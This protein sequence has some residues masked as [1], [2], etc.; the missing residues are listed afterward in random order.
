[1]T[2][3]VEELFKKYPERREDWPKQNMLGKLSR[4]EDFRGAAV[5]LMSPASS[6][7]TAADMR[8]DGGHTSW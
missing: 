8:I 5:F 6:Y 7:M 2:A 1:M 4:P 3:M